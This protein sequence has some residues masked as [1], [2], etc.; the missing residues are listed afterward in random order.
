MRSEPYA[1]AGALRATVRPVA[2][3]AAARRRPARDRLPPV[4]PLVAT[5]H[6]DAEACRRSR[7]R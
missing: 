3:G 6:V 7:P 5:P 1:C 4:R 2:R